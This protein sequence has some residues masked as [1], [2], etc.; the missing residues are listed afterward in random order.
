MLSAARAVKFEADLH[1]WV[2]VRNHPRRFPRFVKTYVENSVA[3]S[4]YRT[5][6]ETWA[7]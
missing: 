3:L 7:S 2:M 4:A 1:L 5:A 6:A